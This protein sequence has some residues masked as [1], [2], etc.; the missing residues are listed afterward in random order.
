M[1]TLEKDTFQPGGSH[2]ASINHVKVTEITTEWTG[3]IVSLEAFLFVGYT[4]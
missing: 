2:A 4:Y 3:A 1:L